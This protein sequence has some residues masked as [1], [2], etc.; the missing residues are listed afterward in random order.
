VTP[1]VRGLHVPLENQIAVW[2]SWN[3]RQFQGQEMNKLIRCMRCC[4]SVAEW[5]V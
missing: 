3:P 5:W 1:D 4:F 2:F